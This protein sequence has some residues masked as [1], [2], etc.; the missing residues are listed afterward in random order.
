MVGDLLASHDG[1][2]V[3]VDDLL[4]TG[5]W[6]TVYNVTVADYHTCFVGDETWGFSVWAH[7]K[8]CSSK[9]QVEEL[10]EGGGFQKRRIG[11]LERPKLELAT[12]DTIEAAARKN[13]AGQFLDKNGKVI[14]KP[15]FG[16]KYG[17][18][19]RRIIEAADRLGMNQ[20]Q[21]NKFVNSH[22]DYFFIEEKAVNLSHVGEKPGGGDLGDIIADMEKFL[23]LR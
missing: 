12:K 14:E 9:I 22:P 16:H 8:S 23:G 11:G 18:E 20:E 3:N 4:D 19:N 5:E 10:V 6:E 15:T 1:Q 2:W 7:N 13:A 21:L 17:F